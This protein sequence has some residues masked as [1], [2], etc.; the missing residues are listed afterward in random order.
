MSM[1]QKSSFLTDVVPLVGQDVAA[2]LVRNLG[3][4]TFPVPKR[5][6]QQGEVRFRMLAA[7]IGEDAAERLVYH[8]GGGDLY[9][10][11]CAAS[12]QEHRDAEINAAYIRETNAGRS[13]K[14]VVN[15]LA[16]KYK[17]TNRRVWD[18]LKTLPRPDTQFRLF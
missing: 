16:R 13:S 7:V 4:T 3:G 12:I 9:I 15:E 1:P 11:R 5:Q 8:F 18:I 14:D 6:S 10:P 2:L 17:L